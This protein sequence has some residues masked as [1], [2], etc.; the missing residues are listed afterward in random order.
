MV[1]RIQVPEKCCMDVAQMY[2]GKAGGRVFGA[3]CK[4]GTAA[5][6][7]AEAVFQMLVPKSCWVIGVGPAALWT[8]LTFTL[9]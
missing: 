5:A 1:A 8:V 6:G 9:P 4:E 7:P 2:P 3:S